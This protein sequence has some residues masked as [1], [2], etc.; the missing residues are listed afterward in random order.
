MGIW[1]HG[2]AANTMN[3]DT[4]APGNQIPYGVHFTRDIDI[5]HDFATGSTKL[6]PTGGGVVYKCEIDDTKLLDIYSK[7]IFTE[8]DEYYKILRDIGKCSRYKGTVSPTKNGVFYHNKYLGQD[9]FINMIDANEVL[10]NATPKCVKSKL[11]KYGFSQGIRYKMIGFKDIVGARRVYTEA[12]CI[13]DQSMVRIVSKEKLRGSVPTFESFN[14]EN[15]SASIT[16]HGSD[17]KKYTIDFLDEKFGVSVDSITWSGQYNIDFVIDKSKV[18]LLKAEF[19][20]DDADDRL[21]D[22]YIY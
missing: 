22:L 18:E 8:S 7:W 2:S 16:C 5:A 11:K 17:S 12:I 14:E 15:V 20:S 6:K 3:F 1:Y 21:G 9:G 4:Y 13:L 19:Y 10:D